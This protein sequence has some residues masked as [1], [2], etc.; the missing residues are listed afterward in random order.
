MRLRAIAAG[1][2]IGIF[3]DAVVLGLVSHSLA[4]IVVTMIVVAVETPFLIWAVTWWA[5]NL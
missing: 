5:K 4:T 2:I 3:I 1:L